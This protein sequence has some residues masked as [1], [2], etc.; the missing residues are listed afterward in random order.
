MSTPDDPT[1][2]T[3]EVRER[4]IAHDDPW[5]DDVS[6]QLRLLRNSVWGV[7]LLAAIALGIGIY[8][9]VTDD[10]DGA[11]SRNVASETRVAEL[12]DRVDE[13]GERSENAVRPRD[14]DQLDQRQSELSD[15]IDAVEEQAGQGNADDL[16]QSIDQLSNDLEQLSQR[17]DEL[18]QEQQQQGQ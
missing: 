13:L 11:D 7:A 3:P 6:A 10:D 2:R 15:R 14:L 18:E 4:E 17:V 9:V 12:E 16:Q 1:R 8:A 5:R